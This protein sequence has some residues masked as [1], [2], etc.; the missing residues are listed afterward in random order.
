MVFC[1]V[2]SSGPGRGA[3]RQS[4]RSLSRV[5]GL[6]PRCAL[7]PAATPRDVLSAVGPPSGR[8]LRNP[9]CTGRAKP[10]HAGGWG[11]EGA[12]SEL[13]SAAA[14]GPRGAR[15]APPNPERVCS[16]LFGGSPREGARSELAEGNARLALSEAVSRTLG[17]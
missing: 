5:A 14:T 10:H 9:E 7:L 1:A 15:S 12:R 4:L 11:R 16:L 2:R 6:V 13:A 3:P 17:P 8:S